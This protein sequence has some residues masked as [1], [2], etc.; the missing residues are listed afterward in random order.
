MDNSETIISKRQNRQE[1]F[2]VL[3]FALLILF[4]RKIPWIAHALGALPVLGASMP[5]FLLS[6]GVLVWS[7]RNGRSLVDFGLHMPHSILLT[8]VWG[9]GAGLFR[10]LTTSVLSP[11]LTQLTGSAPVLTRI[12]PLQGNLLL[13]LILM[14]LMWLTI[15]FGEEVLHRGFIMTRLAQIW[16]EPGGRGY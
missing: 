14:P 2:T 3:F 6:L 4:V 10:L 11:V 5:F 7:L 12:D 16:V 13:L 8:F 1:L 15:G 9:V